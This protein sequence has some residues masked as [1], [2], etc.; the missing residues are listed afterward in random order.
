MPW[1]P[2]TRPKKRPFNPILR[3]GVGTGVEEPRSRTGALFFP[4]ICRNLRGPMSGL[5]PLT[6]SL[7][8]SASP[9][10][11]PR[12]CAVSLLIF[13]VAVCAITLNIAVCRSYCCHRGEE[14]RSYFL[15]NWSNCL[16]FRSTP[17]NPRSFRSARHYNLCL[18][19]GSCSRDASVLR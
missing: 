3:V 10:F 6:C 2:T 9:F 15:R 7:R 8:V 16:W 17:S 5:E 12:K 14:M 1:K 18:H 4:A 13:R 19:I 11:T